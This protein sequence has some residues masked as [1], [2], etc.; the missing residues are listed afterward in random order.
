MAEVA[1][2]GKASHPT[3]GPRAPESLTLARAVGRGQIVLLS[4]HF[5]RYIHSLNEELVT[6]LNTHRV[7]GDKMPERLRLQHSMTPIE[8]LA[9][10]GWESRSQKLQTF[11][12]DEAWLWARNATGVIAH[13]R[14]LVWMKAPH[15]RELVRFFRLWGCDNIFRA[16]TRKETSRSTL[17]LGVQGLVDLRNNIAHG[18][19]T[20]QATQQDVRRYMSSIKKFCVRVDRHVATAIAREYGIPQP[21]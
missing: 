12:A 5:E 1:D 17:W 15:P 4:S 18:D 20:A 3:L 19:Y 21:W 13:E 10:T 11:V 14:L 9:R 8:E 6:F 7:S 2:L 16:I